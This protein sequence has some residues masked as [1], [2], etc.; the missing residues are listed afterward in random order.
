MINHHL[1]MEMSKKKIRQTVQRLVM[2]SSKYQNYNKIGLG[3][4]IKTTML[5][6]ELQ[7]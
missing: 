1:L 7:L 2:I 5:G 6:I 4:F 3:I